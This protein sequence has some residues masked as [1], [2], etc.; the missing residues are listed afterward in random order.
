MGIK[1]YDL[2][3]GMVVENPVE[4]ERWGVFVVSCPHPLYSS[5]RMVVWRMPDGSWSH[6]AL[7]SRQDVGDARPS[8]AEERL[9]NLRWALLGSTEAPAD[10]R[11]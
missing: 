10:I 11:S 8:S 5:L 2:V 7:D 4:P 1:V 6:D 9:S 3:P